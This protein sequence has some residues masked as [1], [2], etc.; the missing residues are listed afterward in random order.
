M[1]NVCLKCLVTQEC[2]LPVIIPPNLNPLWLLYLQPVINL[3]PAFLG[4]THF[5]PRQ[6]SPWFVRSAGFSS[7]PEKRVEVERRDRCMPPASQATTR[8]LCS[9]PRTICPPYHGNNCKH[10]SLA[11][12]GDFVFFFTFKSNLH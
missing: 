6:I 12:G 8:T 1:V 2:P 9:F 7:F 10:V 5:R 4:T 11:K 3:Q